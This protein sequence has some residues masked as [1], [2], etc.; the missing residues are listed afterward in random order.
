M[1][2]VSW[3]EEID[4]GAVAGTMKVQYLPDLQDVLRIA[5]GEQGAKLVVI[6]KED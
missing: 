3:S 1:Y 5:F 6:A 2:R 4:V